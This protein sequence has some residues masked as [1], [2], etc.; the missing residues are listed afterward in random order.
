MGDSKKA[1]GFMD[2]FLT[3]KR[4]RQRLLSDQT[5]PDLPLLFQ[6]RGWRRRFWRSQ[7][8]PWMKSRRTRP[9]H[10]SQASHILQVNKKGRK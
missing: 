4:M 9:G 6:W 3:N 5:W 8:P 10:Q 7:S 2:I 1:T